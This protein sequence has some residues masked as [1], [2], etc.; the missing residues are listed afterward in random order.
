VALLEVDA[1]SVSYGGLAALTEVALTAESG[2]VTGLIGPNGAGKTTLFNVITG[3][4]R[5]NAGTVR[6]DGTDITRL[7]PHR[8]SALGIARTFQR[9]EAFGSLSVR[10]N[11]LVAAEMRSGRESS[12]TATE[13]L[14]ERVGVSDVADERVDTLPIGTARL[15]ELARAL[16]TSPRLLLLDEPS[17]GLNEQE[18]DAL[19]RL[20]ADLAA[21][22][23]AVLLVEHDMPFVMSACAHLH[24]LDFG[25]VIASG[26]PTVVKADPSVIAAYLGPEKAATAT[27]TDQ[28][29]DG[30]PDTPAVSLRDVYAGYGDIEV[31]HGVDLQ[32]GAG[33]VFALLGT[34]GAG[35]STLINVLSGQ[36]APTAG[37]YEL[38]GKVVNGAAPD[39]LARAGV[40][41]I[42]EG[43]GIFRNLTVLENLKMLTHGGGDLA[44]IVDQ[45]FSQFPRLAERQG[46]TA[47]TLSG[48]EQQMLAL[49]RALAT[50]PRILLLD[51]LSMGLAPLVVEQLY[52]VVAEIAA[53][54]V[55]TLVVEQ[56][57]HDILGI[58]HRAAV[59]LHGRI[60]E[61]GSPS[62]IA[63]KLADVYLGER[64]HAN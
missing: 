24:V 51:E 61:I 7:P 10:D 49:A 11:V 26:E 48:G 17:S 19:S 1:V 46:Q 18:T 59:M 23:L 56:F 40:C 33:E 12:T 42:P 5:A 43:R 14:L 37:E 30:N 54:G 32:V 8:R 58:A 25:S 47:G 60:E 4:E 15:V 44:P 13:A 9:L 41:T 63:G 28:R 64:H 20:L 57:A 29:H 3:L 35:K 31:L 21:D 16:A 50:K 55:T 53:E 62:D 27:S 38:F 6:F 52:G 22:N 36:V 34:N 39:L 45:V 2:I